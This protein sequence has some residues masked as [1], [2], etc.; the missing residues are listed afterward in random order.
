MNV[1][2]VENSVNSHVGKVI[3]VNVMNQ[4]KMEGIALNTKKT[5]CPRALTMEVGE[6]VFRISLVSDVCMIR[7]GISDASW[8]STSDD[9]VVERDMAPGVKCDTRA[10]QK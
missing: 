3:V 6:G 5:R 8:L 9:A 4:Y 10:I 2:V 7:A 1:N